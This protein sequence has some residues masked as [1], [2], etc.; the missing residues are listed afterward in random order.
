MKRLLLGIALPASLAGCGSVQRAGPPPEA[1]RAYVDGGL[2]AQAGQLAEAAEAYDVATR[3]DPGSAEVWIAA[4]LAREQL[5]QWEAMVERAQRAHAIAPMDPRP[6]KLLGRAHLARGEL[7]AARD[8]LQRRAELTPERGEAWRELGN[9]AELQGQL[10]A[11]ERA[12]LEATRRAPREP[13]GWLRLGGLRR[14]TNRPAA[15]AAAMTEAVHLD[16]SRRELDPQILALAL[17]SGERDLARAAARRMGGPYARAGAD[18]MMVAGLLL[19][20]NDLLGAA[21]ELEELL[22]RL[23][24]HAE[25]RLMLGLVLSRVERYDEAKGHLAQVPI[26]SP[27][28]PDALR[29]LGNISLAQGDVAQAVELLEQARLRRPERPAFVVDHASALRAAGRLE[30]ALTLLTQGIN[31]WPRHAD[32]RFVRALTMHEI[33]DPDG[34]LWAMH[35]I[36]DFDENHPGALNYIGF[37]WADAGEKLEEAERM[38]RRALKN[39][40]EDAAIVDSLGWVLYRRGEHGEARRVLERAAAL[41]PKRAEIRYH[42]ACV[43]RKLGEEAAARAALAEALERVGGEQREALRRRWRRLEREDDRR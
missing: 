8:A 38:I 17:D 35:E 40:P 22:E 41:D 12:Y 43:L 7:A 1:V 25:G 28:G 20:R 29:L 18:A 24:D 9:V 34:A 27:H 11:A 5:G 33:G 23:P 3:L 26:A 2:L 30:E 13:E 4:A 32:M 42:L 16:P 21:N 14:R 39:S 31:R 19:K 37:T 15:A 10:D 36:L 6:L